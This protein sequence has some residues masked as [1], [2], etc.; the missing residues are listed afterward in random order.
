MLRQ[1][2]AVV[3]GFIL[4]SAVWLG[5]NAGLHAMNVLPDDQTQP[6]QETAVLLALLIG[7]V[8]ASLIAGYVAALAV[9]KVSKP[10]ITALGLLLLA[11]GIFVQVQLWDL[12]P[13]WYHFSF[14]ALLLPVCKF[15]ASLG[16]PKQLESGASTQ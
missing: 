11:T 8:L 16:K 4:W 10:P 14:L 7:G 12:M 1:I 15:G 9:D 13:V 2:L 6:V 3:V 5:Y